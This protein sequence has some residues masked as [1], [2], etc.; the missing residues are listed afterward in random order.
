M[1]KIVMLG[2]FFMALPTIA[3]DIRVRSADDFFAKLSSAPYTVAVFYNR[4]KEVAKDK[5]TLRSIKDLEIQIKSLSQNPFYKGADLQFMRV[6]L[7][8]KDLASVAQQFGIEALP[9]YLLFVGREMVGNPLVGFAYRSKV[10][11][12]IDQNLLDNM[13]I[14]M[15][16]K[17]QQRAR[18]LERAKIQAYRNAYL[19]GPYWNPYW[20][21]G[22]A[23]YWG[24]GYRPYYRWYYW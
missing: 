14:Y 9:T 19:W 24:F 12:F 16:E 10:Q 18:E 8:R 21:Y 22:Y 13:N 23:P 7:D 15:K 11:K 3:K 4:D 6:D 1:K 2:L 20:S 17:Q 5:Q